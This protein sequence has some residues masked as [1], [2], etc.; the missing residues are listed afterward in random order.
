[1]KIGYLGAGSWG[2]CLASLLAKKGYSVTLWT[3]DSSLKETLTQTKTHPRFPDHPVEGN[4]T[5]TTDLKEAITDKDLIVESVTAAGLRDVCEQIKNLGSL[6]TPFV[7][8]SKGIEKDSGLI[9]P[10]VCIDVFGEEAKV[11]VGLISGPGYAQEVIQ[12]LP[13]SL[14]ATA[15]ESKIISLIQKAFSSFTFRVYPNSDIVGVALGGA[16]KNV[17]AIACG[18]CC[19]LQFGKSAQASTLTRGLHE[20]RKFA[21]ALG[22]RSE[23][24]NGLAGLGDLALTCGSHLSRNLQFGELLAQGKGIEEAKI[25]VGTVVE[26]AYTCV[27]AHQLSQKHKI[28]MPL[29]EHVYKIIYEGL[30]PLEA[31]T[32]L[33]QREV[34]EEHL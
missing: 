18:M 25:Q 30:K 33:M 13:T 3:T 11:L 23:T 16:L 6:N 7:I 19:G 14:V 29:T 22:C 2:F 28:A 9:L 20:M 34:K 27:A 4:L 1:M 5:V 32:L 15:Y 21:T 10:E 8:T 12:G 31:V 24:L 17:I 26:G